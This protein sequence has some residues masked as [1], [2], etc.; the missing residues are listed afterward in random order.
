MADCYELRSFT[1][2]PA[3]TRLPAHSVAE[4]GRSQGPREG[5]RV[6]ALLI[7]VAVP[8]SYQRLV[9]V[10]E[11]VLVNE[12]LTGG[13]GTAILRQLTPWWT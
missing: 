12:R 5:G 7:L 6:T 4:A 8:S 3:S 11:D 13:A 9:P 1:N 2:L 10:V